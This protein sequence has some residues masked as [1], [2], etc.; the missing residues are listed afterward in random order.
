MYRAGYG[1]KTFQLVTDPNGTPTVTVLKSRLR[2]D[3]ARMM[4]GLQ[5]WRY[6]RNELRETFAGESEDTKY[7]AF[8]SMTWY[9]TGRDR[10]YAHTALGAEPLA[11]MG[12]GGLYAWA[13]N[14]GEMANRFNDC[15]QPAD[16]G[17]FNDSADRGTFWA[18]Y[19]TTLGAALHELGHA[20][21]LRHSRNPEGIMERGFDHINRIFMLKED[22]LFIL[23]ED[24]CW[25]PASA[26][27]LAGSPWFN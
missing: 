24:I 11:L 20:F 15:R 6:F 3:E 14:V 21:G 9:E 8:M 10:I 2:L 7:M 26:A 22:G 16:Y 1:H 13:H 23:N 19:A 18:V 27:Q 5:L 4:A 12:T 25:A 17:L